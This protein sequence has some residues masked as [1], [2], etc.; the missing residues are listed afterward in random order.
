MRPIWIMAG[1][2]GVFA[3][4]AFSQTKIPPSQLYSSTPP[5][6]L[7]RDYGMP[8]SPMRGL[9]SPQRAKAAKP[10]NES[11]SFDGL[12]TVA[13]PDT[14]PSDVPNFFQASPGVASSYSQ[15][16]DVPNFF[17]TTP[18]TDSPKVAKAASGYSTMETPLFS[19][20]N[21]LPPSSDTTSGD[22]TSSDAPA[23]DGAGTR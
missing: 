21:E 23:A 17:Q 19:T 4:P 15:P 5:A 6:A 12:S 3:A 18:D 9:D 16:T 11:E 1:L 8:Q 10:Q 22:T 14:Q 2:A 7:D 20:A 13:R